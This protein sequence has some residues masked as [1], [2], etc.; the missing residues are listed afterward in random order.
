VRWRSYY[1]QGEQLEYLGNCRA[2][3]TPEPNVAPFA[4]LGLWVTVYAAGLKVIGAL[5]LPSRWFRTVNTC[6]IGFA[7]L[8]GLWWAFAYIGHT[9]SDC[10]L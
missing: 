6:C 2:H 3:P 8:A 5:R 4:L 9:I 1:E 7:V 10:V